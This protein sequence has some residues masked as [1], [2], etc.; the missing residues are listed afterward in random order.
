MVQWF[1]PRQRRN[2]LIM[3]Q[4]YGLTDAVFRD[5][6]GKVTS[7]LEAA[8]SVLDT[9]HHISPQSAGPPEKPN[10][11]YHRLLNFLANH[12]MAKNCILAMELS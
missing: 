2:Y 9:H 5:G 4:S 6:S 10:H 1:T 3:T 12:M 11:N 7:I 8:V